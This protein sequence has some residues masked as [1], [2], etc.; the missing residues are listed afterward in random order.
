MNTKLPQDVLVLGVGNPLMGDDG[1]GIRAIEL[2]ADCDLPE[3]IRIEEIGTPGWALGAW[4]ENQSSVILIDAVQMGLEPGSW[5]KLDLRETKLLAQE[6]AFS[7]HQPDLAN[8]LEL[9]QELR[10]LPANL[11]L[12]GMEPADLIPGNPLSPLI[13]KNMPEFVNTIAKDIRRMI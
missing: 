5:K 9:A 7:L 10:L 11:V 8:G 1:V 12:Y 13:E 6:P 4:F 2:L 3:N